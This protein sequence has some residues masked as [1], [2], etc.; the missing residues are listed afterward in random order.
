M[1][2]VERALD[3]DPARRFASA[4][5]MHA[6]LGGDESRPRPAPSPSI[7]AKLVRV[8]WAV[9]VVLAVTGVLGLL[10]SR[11]FESALRVEP[12]FTAGIADYFLVGRRALLPFGSSG[13]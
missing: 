8:V 1:V 7:W 3:R 10:A 13:R 5:E 4:G 2:T 6:A 11:F 12:A 9:G